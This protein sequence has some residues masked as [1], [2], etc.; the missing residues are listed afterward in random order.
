MEKKMVG[1]PRGKVANAFFLFVYISAPMPKIH[2][3][4]SLLTYSAFIA[5]IRSTN[6]IA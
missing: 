3:A 4:K 2:S 5:N 1:V 6:M